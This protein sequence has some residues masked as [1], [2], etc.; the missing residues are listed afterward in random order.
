MF[1]TSKES[2][3]KFEVYRNYMDFSYFKIFRKFTIT[4]YGPYVCM[5]TFYVTK[6]KI[7]QTL[8]LIVMF[9]KY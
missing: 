1:Q 8:I 6:L 2:F 9:S 4:S 3:L 5:K 7:Y